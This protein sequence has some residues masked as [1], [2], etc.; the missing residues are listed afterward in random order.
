MK[1]LLFRF[2]RIIFKSKFNF[3]LFHFFIF[4]LSSL[5]VW[6]LTGASSFIKQEILM[7]IVPLILAELVILLLSGGFEKQKKVLLENKML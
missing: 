4:F 1:Q 3:Y 6:L 2:R 5:S 7:L